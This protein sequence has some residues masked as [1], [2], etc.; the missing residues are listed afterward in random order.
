MLT[1]SVF[2]P[3]DNV[4]AKY[5]SRFG[6]SLNIVRILSDDNSYDP[7]TSTVTTEEQL[8]PVTGMLWDLTLQ[9]NGTGL[10][11]N[12]L[13]EAG[14]KQLLI[15]PPSKSSE[16]YNSEYNCS[17]VIPGKDFIRINDDTYKI[18]TFKEYN[19]NTTNSVL[20]E[21]FIRK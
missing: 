8:I 5:M 10:Y 12:T 9:S 15:Q 7:I 19:P 16:Y 14:D 2:S 6:F 11:K 17:S 21:C 18:I 4:V 13:I 3:F 20:W 1:S